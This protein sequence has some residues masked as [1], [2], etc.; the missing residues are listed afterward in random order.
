MKV[1][2]GRG[3]NQPFTCANCG[4][5]VPA[6]AG[7]GYRNH[8]PRCLC[9]LHVDVFPGDRANDCHGILRPVGAVPGKKGWVIVSQCERCGEVRRNRAALDEPNE[10][11]DYDFIIALTTRGAP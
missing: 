6:L 10:P 5:D 3:A 1:F 2:T 9:S 11:D 7:G 4:F 8:C